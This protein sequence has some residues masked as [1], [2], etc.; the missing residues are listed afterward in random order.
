MPNDHLATMEYIMEIF[1]KLE[2]E[3]FISLE[4]FCIPTHIAL[5]LSKQIWCYYIIKQIQVPIFISFCTGTILTV[6]AWT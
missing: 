4:V 3:T 1:F 5:D 2:N 6:S